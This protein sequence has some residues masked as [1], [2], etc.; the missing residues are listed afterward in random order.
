MAALARPAGR[1]LLE[2]GG[3]KRFPSAISGTF[4]PPSNANT[5]CAYVSVCVLK[6]FY[7]KIFSLNLFVSPITS[8]FFS[9]KHN[10]THFLGVGDSY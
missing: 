4:P 9:K 10:D 1:Q 7:L 8:T 3:Q 6:F 5:L 2:L